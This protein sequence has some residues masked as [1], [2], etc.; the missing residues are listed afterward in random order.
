[1]RVWVCGLCVAWLA[2]CSQAP[3]ARPPVVDAS[4]RATEDD[5]RIET[6]APVQPKPA[7]RAAVKPPV[8]NLKP[9]PIRSREYGE[10]NAVTPVDP[11]ARIEPIDKPVSESGMSPAVLSLLEQADTLRQ[12]GDLGGALSRLERAQRIA[13]D[14]PEIYYQMSSVRFEQGQFEDAENIAAQA[15]DLSMTD[16]AMK[17]DLYTLIARAREALGDR[18]GAG[19]ARRLARNFGS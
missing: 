4:W 11:V 17:R 14:E 12:A 3:I 18:D 6:P 5:R 8:D 7:P 19:E 9:A 10:V 16:N 13:P 1:M 15:V 2:G